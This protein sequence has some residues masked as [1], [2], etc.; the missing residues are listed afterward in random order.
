MTLKIVGEDLPSQPPAAIYEYTRGPNVEP[1][2]LRDL[3]PGH[4]KGVPSSGRLY[5]L[6]KLRSGRKAIFVDSKG[7]GNSDRGAG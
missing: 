5:R 1:Y 6:R 7:P 4:M 3:P 2:K